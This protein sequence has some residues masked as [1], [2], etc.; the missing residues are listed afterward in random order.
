MKD[1]KEQKAMYSFNP[2]EILLPQPLDSA[3]SKLSYSSFSNNRLGIIRVCTV[4]IPATI[5]GALKIA[6][7]ASRWMSV[8]YF[9]SIC[10]A[11]VALAIRRFILVTITPLME[12]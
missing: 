12:G 9:V 5:S 11:V 7:M 4:A 2:V 1:I 10:F 6:K 3:T 8:S